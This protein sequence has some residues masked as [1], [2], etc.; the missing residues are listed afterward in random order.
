MANLAAYRQTNV[1]RLLA[2]SSI[3][4]AGYMLCAGAIVLRNAE[5]SAAAM[6]AVITYLLIYMFMNYGAFLTVGLVAEDTGSEELSAFT[7][8]GYRDAPTSASLTICLV[9]LVGLP[10]MGGFVVKWW[11]LWA[12]G[13]AAQAATTGLSALFWILVIAVVINTAISLFYYTRVIREMYL[14]GIETTTGGALK[15]PAWGKL[16]LHVCAVVILLTGTLLIGTVKRGTER[17]V[18]AGS[19]TPT[20][21]SVSREIAARDE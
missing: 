20:A 14:R 13:D 21:A 10:P 11:L 17:V 3:A 2:Y 4:H 19:E 16:A 1:R 8:L 18:Q 15:A 6:G 5:I 9:S 12:L 7:G